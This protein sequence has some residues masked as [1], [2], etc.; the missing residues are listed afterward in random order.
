MTYTTTKDAAAEVR[1]ALKAKGWNARAV[2]VRTD[3]YSGGSSLDVTIR[4]PR[5][6]LAVVERIAKG[7]E[8]IHRCEITGETLAGSNRYVSVRYTPEAT[9]AL[10]APL[11]PALAT[12][13]ERLAALPDGHGLDVDGVPGA[14]LFKGTNGYG[15]VVYLNDARLMEHNTLAGA[16]YGL[17]VASQ[18]AK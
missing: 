11:L 1:A 4:D 2:S 13:A 12:T 7:S 3:Y 14:V 5:V 16:A 17:A 9:A 15:F 8:R 10:S 18:V 6:P